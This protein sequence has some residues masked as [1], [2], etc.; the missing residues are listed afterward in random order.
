MKNKVS[1][2]LLF[3]CFFSL[4]IACNTNPSEPQAPV[5]DKEQ[6]KMEIQ[7]K[8]KEFADLYNSGE[9][10]SI[11]YYADDAITYYQNRLPLIGREARA[12]FLKSDI[13]SNTNTIS[14]TTNEVFISNDGNLV[15]EVGAYKVVDSTN[16]AVNTGNYM[17]LFEK[18]D[19][20][21]VCIRDMSASDMPLE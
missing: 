17:S 15:V 6:V 20:R 4:T 14:F 9:I 5:V 7:A 8:E 12:E 3:F 1:Q 18:R 19:G 21:Y 10:K 13:I 16:T 2:G 11:G